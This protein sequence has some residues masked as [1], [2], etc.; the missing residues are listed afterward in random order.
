MYLTSIDLEPFMGDDVKK[1]IK[2]SKNYSEI[3]GKSRMKKTN[4]NQ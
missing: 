3:V 4:K 2:K 1:Y